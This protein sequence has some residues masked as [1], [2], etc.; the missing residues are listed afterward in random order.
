MLTFERKR[1]PAPAGLAE[2]LAGHTVELVELTF[3]ELMTAH[4]EHPDK[5]NLSILAHSLHIDGE[6][7]GFESLEALPGSWND[8]VFDA[9]L[10]CNT[11]HGKR[12]KEQQGNA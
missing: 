10:E 1:V 4:E 6:S 11:L 5:P 7:I 8:D 12:R 9:L 3:G 2:K